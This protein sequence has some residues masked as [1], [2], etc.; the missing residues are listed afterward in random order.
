MSKEIWFISRL[1]NLVLNM[2]CNRKDT[3]PFMDT[4]PTSA[5]SNPRKANCW[6]LLAVLQAAFKFFLSESA[7]FLS[8][9]TPSITHAK[10]SGNW[11]WPRTYT[12]V[13]WTG[14]Q[15]VW[16]ILRGMSQTHLWHC[17]WHHCNISKLS[18]AKQLEDERSPYWKWVPRICTRLVTQL[19]SM[20][21]LR[22]DILL[23]R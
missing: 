5:Q 22:I 11:R 21:P 23:Q 2:G 20:C 10:E 3:Y 6:T 18:T 4:L 8:Y 15:R 1:W 16:R 12:Y 14:G 17:K 9:V 13:H 19:C 7:S